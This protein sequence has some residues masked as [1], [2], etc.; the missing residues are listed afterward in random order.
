M[1]TLS[2]FFFFC[3]FNFDTH[4]RKGEGK[5]EAFETSRKISMKIGIKR[6]W[7]PLHFPIKS[8]T[9]MSVP[10]FSYFIFSSLL[11][12]TAVQDYTPV[13]SHTNNRGGGEIRHVSGARNLHLLSRPCGVFFLLFF[14]TSSSF[15]NDATFTEW[16]KEDLRKHDTENASPDECPGTRWCFVWRGLDNS[17]E[18]VALSDGHWYSI[19]NSLVRVSLLAAC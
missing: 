19:N 5:R 12:C 17:K 10:H 4:A 16:H 15:T 6:A 7:G 3:V 9:W 14:W 1:D 8:R 18:Q 11:Y 2:L 13:T